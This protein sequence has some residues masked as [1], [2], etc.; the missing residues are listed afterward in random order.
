MVSFEEVQKVCAKRGI[1]YPTAEIYPTLSGF[2]DYGPIG[3]LLKRKLIDYWRRTFVKAGYNVFEIDGCTIL[4]EAVL[5]ASGHLDFFTDP[6]TRCEKCN[7]VFKADEL[8][9]ST[10]KFFGGKTPDELTDI[11]RKNNIKCKKCGSRLSDVKIFNLMFRTEV[12]PMGKHVAYLRPETAQNIFT[13]FQKIY[14]TYR[15]SL[16]FGIAQVGH[17]FRNEISPRQFIIRLREFNQCEIEM[18]F[19]PENPKCPTGEIENKEINL[20][21]REA[22]KNNEEHK[23]MKVKDALNEKILPNEW[24]GYFLAKEFDFYKSLGIPESALRFRHMLPEETPHYSSG[25]FDLEI[26]F[27]FGWK[28]VVGNACRNDYDLRNHMKNSG[29]NMTITTEDGKKIIPHVVEPSFGIE[30][31]IAGILFYCFRKDRER[32]WDWFRFPNIISP[33]VA[34][35]FPLVN[36]NGFQEKAKSIYEMLRTEF[37]VFY[38][39]KG[40]IG[41]RYARADEIGTLMGITI[42][43]QTM[44]DDTVTIRNRDTTKQ[45]REEIK[46]LKN[47]ISNQKN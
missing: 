27:D 23:K 45:I 3:V 47:I 35:I 21:T 6:I 9:E 34:G 5:K 25:N 33:Y 24:I 29:T 14:K 32:G 11:I 15:V 43:A 28:E 31:T 20:L 37:D 13:S 44:R 8:I 18:F 10:C 26:R 30:R 39:D 12:S 46:N 36:R 40:S 1:I 19:D 41:K 38:D 4:P 17:A 7:S 16:P 2:F 42:D 22:Q